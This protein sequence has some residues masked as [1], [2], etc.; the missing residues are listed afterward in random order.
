M[1]V[2]E[3]YL[4]ARGKIGQTNNFE[5]RKQLEAEIVGDR[6]RKCYLPSFVPC[7]S[8]IKEAIKLMK[9]RAEIR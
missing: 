1:I 9:Y 2:D 3:G 6:L 4:L 7:D 5:A 8:G